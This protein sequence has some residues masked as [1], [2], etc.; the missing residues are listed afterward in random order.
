MAQ[1]HVAAISGVS[2]SQALRHGE[3]RKLQTVLCRDYFALLNVL[4]KVSYK[5]VLDP[6]VL[7]EIYYSTNQLETKMGKKRVSLFL[8]N[9]ST[10][11]ETLRRRQE[12]DGP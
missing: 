1:A 12:T 6:R 8:I 4:K 2:L 11:D 9:I 3:V 10:R 7:C 5:N